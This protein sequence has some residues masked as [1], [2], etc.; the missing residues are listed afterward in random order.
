M[1][2]QFYLNNFNI[3]KLIF[4]IMMTKNK[5][6]NHFHRLYLTEH[7]IVNAIIPI[8]VYQ[9]K[10]KEFKLQKKRSLKKNL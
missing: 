2:I 8:L 1:L 10:N 6:K 9:I 3:M 4:K 7:F 5:F